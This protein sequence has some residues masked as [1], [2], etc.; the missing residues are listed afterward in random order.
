MSDDLFGSDNFDNEFVNHMVNM[1]DS[2][3]VNRINTIKSYGIDIN[4][5]N[6]EVYLK[7]VINSNQALVKCIAPESTKGICRALLQSE[8]I[9][10]RSDTNNRS[11]LNS[12]I[13][14]VGRFLLGNMMT[15][16]PDV[17]NPRCINLSFMD[18]VKAVESY[19]D[20]T[21]YKNAGLLILRNCYDAQDYRKAN[22]YL[23]DILEFRNGNKVCQRTTLMSLK[24]KNSKM[25]CGINLSQSEYSN[26]RII[27]MY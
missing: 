2:K 8:V 5:V 7:N 20:V 19:A 15:K 10:L 18:F 26:S 11:T 23:D 14:F 6:R 4:E 25:F 17:S 12:A 16:T 24:D 9:V 1:E 22:D 3:K 27:D 21:V 13:N